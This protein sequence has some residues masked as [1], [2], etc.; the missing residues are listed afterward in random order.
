MLE[1]GGWRLKAAGWR[2]GARGWRLEAA[3]GW[4]V[5][6]GS[7]RLE[8]GISQTRACMGVGARAGRSGESSLKTSFSRCG[9]RRAPKN[10]NS[11]VSKRFLF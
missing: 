3:G 4:R 2:R 6:A 1:A 8:G 5:E 9:G 11:E 7:W 10:P